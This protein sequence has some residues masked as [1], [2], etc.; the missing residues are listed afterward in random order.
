MKLPIVPFCPSACYKIEQNKLTSSISQDAL[1]ILVPSQKG[2]KIK[3]KT[4][5]MCPGD[6]RHLSRR[7][8]ELIRLLMAPD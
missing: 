1:N 5:S 7:C 4:S 3:V 2:T 8:G 6:A